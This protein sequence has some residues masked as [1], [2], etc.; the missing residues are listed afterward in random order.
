MLKWTCDAVG[1]PRASVGQW[2]GLIMRGFNFTR[3][4]TQLRTSLSRWHYYRRYST[5]YLTDIDIVSLHAVW[6]TR[7]SCFAILQTRIKFIFVKLRWIATSNLDFCCSS[8]WMHS[9][10][11][12]I[13]CEKRFEYALMGDFQCVV[14][15][16]WAFVLETI[17]IN[18]E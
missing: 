7:I 9:P 6:T 5:E 11:K 2:T 18:F 4:T 14:D 12:C 17:L 13:Y 1:I 16:W 10:G 15:D 8:Q 3:I